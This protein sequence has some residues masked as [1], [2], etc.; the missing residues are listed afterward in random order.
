MSKNSSKKIELRQG[1][2]LVFEV[3]AVKVHAYQSNDPMADE[4]FILEK[5][6]RAL[7]IE[8][9]CFVDSIAELNEYVRSLPVKVEGTL[10]S[11]HMAGATFLPDVPVYATRAAD[12]FAHSGGGKAL[13]TGFGTTFGASFDATIPTVTNVIEP[14]EL[15]LAGFRLN[16]VETAN[17]FDIEIPELNAVYIH[18]LGHDVHSIVAGPED[19]DAQL[20]RLR[21]IIASGANLVLSS[22]Y[23]PEDDADVRTKVNYLEALKTF[24]SWNTTADAFKQAVQQTFPN[25]NGANYLDMTAGFF[26]PA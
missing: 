10:L 5:D 22:H 20:A 25:Y 21:E 23:V 24:A 8:A 11:Y 18:M 3:G 9:P 6:G 16:I 12:E 17:A 13:V 19:A 14:G 1:E 26:F 4:V 15:E 2:V 7:V